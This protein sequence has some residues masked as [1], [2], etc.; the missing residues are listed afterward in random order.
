MESDVKWPIA[1]GNIH[2]WWVWLDWLLLW[3]EKR[4]Y[5][6]YYYEWPNAKHFSHNLQPHSKHKPTFYSLS[7]HNT[8]HSQPPPLSLVSSRACPTVPLVRH[9]KLTADLTKKMRYNQI[10]WVHYDLHTTSKYCWYSMNSSLHRNHRFP[11][12]SC[13]RQQLPL[14]VRSEWSLRW[15]CC[16]FLYS[17]YS[18]A[19]FISIEAEIRITRTLW[20]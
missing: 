1:E 19:N 3:W 8:S 16:H 7:S 12:R 4:P 5:L 15:R 9:S 10:H 13:P 6:D 2:R 20:G 18:R 14:G 11:L 17:S